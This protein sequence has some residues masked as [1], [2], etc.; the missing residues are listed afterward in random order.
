[1]VNITP[2]DVFKGVS[3]GVSSL[4]LPSSQKSSFEDTSSGTSTTVL[5]IVIILFVLYL[6]CSLVATYKLTHSWL[7]VILCILFGF[8]YMS[9]AYM[10]YGLSGYKISK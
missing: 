8:F 4:L 1:M 6:Y 9:I 10:Y 2:D 5:V 7:Q 3:L